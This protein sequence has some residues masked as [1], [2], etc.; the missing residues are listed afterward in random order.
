MRIFISHSSRDAELARALIDLLQAALPIA[1]DEIRCSSVDGYR[2]PGGV[3][4]DQQLRSEVHE[5][6]LVIGL[7]T[8]NSLASAYV[9]FELG[10]RWG[11]KKPMIPLL[12]GGAT[13][14]ILEGPL[15]GIN[16]LD[17]RSDGQIHQLVEET[18]SHLKVEQHR[19]STFTHQV[20][21]LLALSSHATTVE[22]ESLTVSTAPQNSERFETLQDELEVLKP[23]QLSILNDFCATAHKYWKEEIVASEPEDS[24]SRFPYGYYELGFALVDAVPA[25]GVRELRNRL[26]SAQNTNLSGWSPFLDMQ[27]PGLNPYAH[28][29]FVEAWTGRR[30]EGKQFQDSMYCDFWRASL[31]GKLYTIRG[32][33]EDSSWVRNRGYEPGEVM[34]INTPILRV[35]EGILFASRFAEGFDGVQG[36][37]TD[38][39]FAGL[40]DRYMLS[41]K[42]PLGN[43][44]KGGF[45]THTPYAGLPGKHIELAEVRDKLPEIIHELLKGFFAR[46]N[47]YELTLTQVQNSLQ[48]LGSL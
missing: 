20:R 42:S 21:K 9:S 5:A 29:D 17:C 10:A 2:L 31:D 43:F 3:S 27:R 36:I 15:G 30:V 35:A 12:A 6:G 48:E 44:W 33:H 19:T 47:F 38:C 37:A 16:A 28:D 25:D 11:A 7:L 13:P 39:K 22:D 24:P 23:D 40:S 8:P 1:S 46:F 41:L 18:A 45:V 34:D 26:R 14:D 32:Y 4:I